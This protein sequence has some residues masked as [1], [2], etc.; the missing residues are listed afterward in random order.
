M[1][2]ILSAFLAI[3]LLPAV[4]LLATAS[5]PESL[6]SLFTRGNADYQKGDFASA[7]NCYRQMLHA[8]LDSASLY[9]NLGNACFK[10]KKLGEAIYF[11][12]KARQNAPDDPDAQENLDLAGLMVVDRLDVPPDPF[13]LRMFK[14]FQNLMTVSQATWMVFFLFIICNLLFS[15]YILA[16]SPNLAYR[17]LIGGLVTGILVLILG[18]SVA[19][20]IYDNNHQL[21]G[22]VVEEK[23]DVRSG[24]GNENITVFTVHE[25]TKVRVRGEAN[26][27]YQVSLPNG[28]NGWLQTSAIL[29]L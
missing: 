6:A 15:T 21:E 2:W 13:P 27:W 14:R 3:A 22:I 10:Q 19:W 20:R 11:W 16:R 17:A 1:R 18:C 5:S 29:V 8:G 28:W 9:Y 4:P 12:E 26:G 7:E 24:P 23:A 25:G